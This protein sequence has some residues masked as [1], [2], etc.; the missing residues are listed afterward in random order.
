MDKKNLKEST[1]A[2]VTFPRL[3]FYS[4][5]EIMA[6]G[7]PEKFAKELGKNARKFMHCLE[8]LPKDVLLTDEE[9]LAAL[10]ILNQH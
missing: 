10:E 4:I 8:K 7:G 2:I 6:A 3:K 5:D 9:Y 1:L